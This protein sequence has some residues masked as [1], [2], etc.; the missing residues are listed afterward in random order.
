M[1]FWKTS[2]AQFYRQSTLWTSPCLLLAVSFFSLFPQTCHF[3]IASASWLP[4]PPAEL[5]AAS[6]ARLDVR[7][8]SADDVHVDGDYFSIL[9]LNAGLFFFFLDGRPGGVETRGGVLKHPFANVCLLHLEGCLSFSNEQKHHLWSVAAT[10]TH[11]TQW[12]YTRRFITFS[13]NFNFMFTT[14]YAADRCWRIQIYEQ[15]GYY[16]AKTHQIIR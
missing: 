14:F 13:C 16:T 10:T 8:T 11:P 15:D 6:A 9:L 3:R 1:L 5:C 7:F 12:I 2:Q 4:W